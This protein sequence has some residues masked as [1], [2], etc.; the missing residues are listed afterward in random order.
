MPDTELS[1]LPALTGA[2]ADPAADMVYVVDDSEVA[3]ARSKHMLLVQLLIGLAGGAAVTPTELGFLAAVT[4]DI[5][6]QLDGK[7]AGGVAITSLTGAV[8]A[9]GPGA[10]AATIAANAVTTAKIGDNQVTLAKLA[11]QAAATILANATGGAAVPTAVE[12][13]FGLGFVSGK[14]A[15]VLP[16]VTVLTD[17]AT[18]AIDAALRGPFRVTLADNRT[19]GAPTNPSDGQ[20]ITIEIIQDTTGGRTLA[21]NAIWKFGTDIAGAVLSTA[22]NAR[23]HF[24]AKYNAANTRW[25]VL[26]FTRVGA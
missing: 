6:A 24:T 9:T 22:A 26:A 11:T 12:L 5:Q 1:N 15:S 3:G 21:Y 20:T 13:G 7:Q 19:L 10:A 23:D 18:I 4:S 25:D 16:A 14:L 2:L 17:A 8:T